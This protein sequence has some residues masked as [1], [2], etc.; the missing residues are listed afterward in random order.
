VIGSDARLDGDSYRVIGVMPEGFGFPNRNIDAY[1]P[2]GFT[3]AQMSDAARG[4]QFSFSVGRLRDGATV[5]GLNAELAAI[6]ERNVAAGRVPADAVTIAGFTGSSQLLRDL[7]V[8]NRRQT[9]VVLQAIVLVVLLIACANLA[10]LQLT[11]IAA[12]RKELAVRS[13][14]GAGGDRL[15]RMVLVEALLLAV[16]GGVLGLGVATGGIG[17]VRALGL[18]RSTQGFEF[19]LDA[20]AL[21]FTLGAAVLA[22]LASGLPPVLAMLRDD[23]TGAIREG[24]RQGGGGRRAQRLRN[25]LVVSQ[26]AMGVVLLVGAGLLTKSFYGLLAEGPGFNASSVWTVRI[27]LAGSRYG[28]PDSWPRFQQAA[29]E[30]LRGLPGVVDAGVTSVL[31]FTGNNS[32]ASFDIDRYVL[33]EGVSP[34]HAQ[35]R[36]I[37]DH[38]LSVLGIPVVEGRNFVAHESERVAIVDENVANKYWPNGSALGQRVRS[39]AGPADE[40]YTIV[41]VVPAV[42]HGTLAETPIKETIYSHYEQRPQ[43]AVVLALRTVVPPAQLAGPVNAAILALDPEVAPYSAQTMDDLVEGS[44]GPQRTPMVLTLVFGG[45]AFL[46]AV[47]GIYGVLAW[48][49]SQRVNEIGVRMALGAGAADIGRM[50]LTQGGKLIAMGLVIGIAGAI[51]LGRVLSSQLDRV[52]SFDAT[53]LALTVVGLGGAA[54]LASWLPARRASRVDPMNALRSE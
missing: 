27:A 52:G 53:V 23:L 37:D 26:L 8:G 41:G 39:S 48:G 42:K 43:S 4:N 28:E 46:L 51:G 54:L 35:V 2:F 20:A 44:L 25:V 38:Y 50:I 34:L 45:V 3:P 5:E 1:V 12:R 31:P 33:P 24:G 40:W 13:A 10:N 7:Q 11:R 32:Q 29:L 30:A 47:I 22:A 17:L 21:G 9:V 36:A 19:A 6:V 18:D 15:V 49:V 16:A 14:L